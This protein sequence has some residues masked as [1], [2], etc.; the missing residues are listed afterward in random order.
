VT[1]WSDK[2]VEF[3]VPVEVLAEDATGPALRRLSLA[4]NGRETNAVQISIRV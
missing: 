2:E 4:V 1:S 3:L